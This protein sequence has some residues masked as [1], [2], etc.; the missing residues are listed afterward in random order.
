MRPG[1]GPPAEPASQLTRITAA[2]RPQCIRRNG[3][4]QRVASASARGPRPHSLTRSV[5]PTNAQCGTEA[6]LCLQRYAYP[7]GDYLR[8]RLRTTRQTLQ[9]EY[10]WRSWRY[11]HPG[12]PTIARLGPYR[13]FFYAGDRGE[14]P[15]VHVEREEMV[16]KFW[17]DGPSLA[18]TRGFPAHEL[19]KLARL[20]AQHRQEFAEA[21]NDYFGS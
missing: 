18:E 13:F 12:V 1:A 10:P 11:T 3:S 21:W 15:H 7:E 9:T 2:R 17:L 4:R 14:P 5:R 8:Q 20:V 6:A 19:R 16:A